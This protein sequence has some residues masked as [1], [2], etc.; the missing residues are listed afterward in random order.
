MS[1]QHHNDRSRVIPSTAIPLV[2]SFA[3]LAGAGGLLF[4]HAQSRP[5][6]P[7]VPGLSATAPTLLVDAV[8]VQERAVQEESLISGQIQPIHIATVAAEVANRIVTRPI[9]QGQRVAQ[10][11]LLATLDSEAAKTAL[12]QAQDGLAQAAAARA[13]AEADYTRAMVETDAARQQAQA[14]VEQALAEER[15]ARAGVTQA[16]AGVR[17]SHS[18][19]RAQEMQQAEEALSQARTDERLAKIECDRYTYLVSRGATAQQTLDHAQATLEGAVARRVSAEQAVSLAQEGARREDQEA[20]KAQADAAAAQA[21]SAARQVD[22]ARAALRIANT[23]DTRL[24]VL[25]RQIDGLRAQEAAAADAVRQARIA[26]DRRA[27]RAPFTG[28]VLATLA[29]AGE[30]TA[31]GTPIARLGEIDRVKAT[32]AVP[33][34]LR[35]GLAVGQK[36]ALTTDAL[37]NRTFFGRIS[38][39]GFQADPKSRAFPIEVTVPNADEALLPNMVARLRLP[40]GHAVTHLLIPASAIVGDGGTTYV[41]ALQGGR[42]HRRDVRLGA[43]VGDRVEITDGLKPGD[44]IATTPQRLS[45]NAEI[46]EVSR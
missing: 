36:V 12:A 23:R 26:L 28:R 33:E 40:F 18:F 45:E 9:E 38:T 10:G 19:T 14:G 37:P 22:S 29:D 1:T 39:L 6:K 21:D 44:R 30:L 43:P 5:T 4:V 15:R 13:Q 42:A 46:R 41:F 8:T 24:V 2:I 17:K 34:A 3:A 25:R 32:F 35:P 31:P 11:G 27:I 20:A 7:A 16:D